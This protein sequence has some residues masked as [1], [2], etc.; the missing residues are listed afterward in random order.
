[1]KASLPLSS[2]QVR[3]LQFIQNWVDSN[4]TKEFK[5][6][7]PLGHGVDGTRRNDNAVARR[8]ETL[9]LTE[10]QQTD[11]EADIEWWITPKGRTVLKDNY[12]NIKV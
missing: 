3:V 11:F 2:A 12:Q 7:A 8:L 10:S 1:M 6:P 5:Y 9:G 4:K